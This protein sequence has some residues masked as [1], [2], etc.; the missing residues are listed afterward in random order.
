MARGW[1]F[2]VFFSAVSLVYRC[3]L[4]RLG[5][6]CLTAPC[7]AFRLILLA[8][9]VW[10]GVGFFSRFLPNGLPCRAFLS[11]GLS[12]RGLP[13][14]TVAHLSAACLHQGLSFPTAYLAAVFPHAAY[15]SLSLPTLPPLFL[16]NGLPYHC[17][18][19]RG[20]PFST[21]ALVLLWPLTPPKDPR[22]N[23]TCRSFVT[24]SGLC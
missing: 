9:G 22:H 21:V 11:N 15:I 16:S 13:F 23:G 5:P 24:E 2:S 10:Q 1:F 8:A 14:P 12:L 20:L 3:A 4:I 19:L 7:F 17:L 6:C 18:S